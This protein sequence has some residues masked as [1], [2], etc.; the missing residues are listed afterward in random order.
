MTILRD[1]SNAL[2]HRFALF[3]RLDTL[4]MVQIDAS[5]AKH[6]WKA[7]LSVTILW[8]ATNVNQLTIW[9]RQSI[10]ARLACRLLRVVLTVLILHSVFHVR[11]GITRTPPPDFANFVLI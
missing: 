2:P 9:I 10:D 1:V 11:M 8:H 4:L 3:V 5:C 6:H 7:V